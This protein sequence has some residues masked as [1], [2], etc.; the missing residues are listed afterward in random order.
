M[1]HGSYANQSNLPRRAT[2]INVFKDGVQSATDDALLAGVPA[3]AKGQKMEGQ[4]FPVLFDP[5]QI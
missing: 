2:L 5:A 1:V 3:I 4:F